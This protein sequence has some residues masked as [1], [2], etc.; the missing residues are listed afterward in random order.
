[1]T[2]VDFDHAHNRLISSLRGI[3]KGRRLSDC[4]VVPPFGQTT[5]IINALND[6]VKWLDE[7]FHE[8]DLA[9]VDQALHQC[10]VV[11]RSNKKNEVAK[12]MLEAL[13]ARKH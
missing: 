1:M 11:R 5:I 7:E 6:A 10:G 12:A 2:S 3:A 8:D 13:V 4:V 9:L